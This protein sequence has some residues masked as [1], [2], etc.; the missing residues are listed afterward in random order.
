MNTA[1][2]ETTVAQISAQ[3]TQ[4]AL[5]VVPPTDTPAP[6]AA[7]SDLPTL[8]LPVLPDS[9]SVSPTIDAAA[10]PTFSFVTTPAAATGAAPIAATIVPSSGGQSNVSTASGCNDALFVGETLPDGS[11]ISTGANFTKAW[12]LQNT[13]TCTWNAGYSFAFLPDVSSSSIT[14]YDVIIKANDAVTDPGHSQSFVVKL[15][16]PAAAG[17]Y[18]GYWKMKAP[19]GTFFG[20]RVYFDIVVK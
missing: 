7:L 9:S 15:T 20:P 16:A 19:D 4:T 8:A 5:A 12:E 13:G 18:K 17:E 1:I 3:F 11:V 2:V 14:G 6:V 10:L